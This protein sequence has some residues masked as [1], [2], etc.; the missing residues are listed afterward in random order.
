[1]KIYEVTTPTKK[2]KPA[3]PPV[4]PTPKNK[5]VDKKLETASLGSYIESVARN[6]GITGVHLANFL[7]QCKVETANWASLK[8]WSDGWQYDPSVNPRAA[9]DLGNIYKGDGPK[10]KGRGFIHLTGRWNYEECGKAIGVDLVNRPE[11]V[12][13]DSKIA[14][15]STL[16]FWN[17][18]IRPNY[19]AN[20]IHGVSVRVNGSN[21]NGLAARVTAFNEY[22]KT[23]LQPL[24][25][26]TVPPNPFKK[27]E[28]EPTD[29]T[30]QLAAADIETDPEQNVA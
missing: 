20:D 12:E 16:W 11:L 29:A 22:V 30:T 3:P 23:L 2:K 4:T 7:A 27:A 17:R 28:V 26:K 8:E 15:Q 5:I 25:K 19:K 18:F 9:K 6:N 24:N 1:M 21:P 13:T 14:G 10:Y